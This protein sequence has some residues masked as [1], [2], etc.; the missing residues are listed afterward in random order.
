MIL[1]EPNNG[2]V[3]FELGKFSGS[4][5]YMTDVPFDILNNLVRHFIDGD[6]FAVSFDE[7]GSRFT[8]IADCYNTYVISVRDKFRLYHTDIDSIELANKLIL[9]IETNIDGWA[10]WLCYDTEIDVQYRKRRILEIIKE[11]RVYINE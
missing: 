1:G 9:S 3:H 7:E 2:W 10:N 11:L 4:M 8:L 6:V 5:S